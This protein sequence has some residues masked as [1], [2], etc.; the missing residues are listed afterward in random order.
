MKST[1]YH[2]GGHGFIY[3]AIEAMDY[4]FS[5]ENLSWQSNND[6]VTTGLAS[7]KYISGLIF[8]L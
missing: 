5:Q 6:M 2:D 8:N 3:I 4:Q 7:G 1:L